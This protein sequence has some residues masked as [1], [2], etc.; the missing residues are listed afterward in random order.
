LLRQSRGIFGPN[1]GIAAQGA[2]RSHDVTTD[3]ANQEKFDG[4]VARRLEKA[5]EQYPSTSR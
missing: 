1:E 5:A 2:G 4:K 3:L